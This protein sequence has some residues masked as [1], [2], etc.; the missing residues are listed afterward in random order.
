MALRRGSKVV[1]D[2]AIF[3]DGQ[4]K[5]EARD[6]KRYIDTRPDAPVVVR[7]MRRLARIGFTETRVDGI[8]TMNQIVRLRSVFFAEQDPVVVS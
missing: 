5:I 1:A 7:Y 3:E 4:V 2:V 6:I 8:V